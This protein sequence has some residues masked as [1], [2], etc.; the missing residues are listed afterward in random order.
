MIFM[1]YTKIL[2]IAIQIKKRKVLIVF[3]D[4]V[5]DMINNKKLQKIVT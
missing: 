4:M 5:V 2:K 1:M 3:D